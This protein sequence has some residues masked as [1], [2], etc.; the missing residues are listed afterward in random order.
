MRCVSGNADY[1]NKGVHPGDSITFTLYPKGHVIQGAI[2]TREN[3]SKG[4]K[5]N[6]VQ[7]RGAITS[8]KM[9]VHGVLGRRT[10]G[11]SEWICGTA[12]NI[13]IFRLFRTKPRM[14]KM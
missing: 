3:H 12:A 2:T 13:P 5:E 4:R 7:Y 14:C 6:K 10:D 9:V 11:A 1:D 8:M